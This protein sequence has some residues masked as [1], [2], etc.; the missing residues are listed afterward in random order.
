M[1][2]TEI[3]VVYIEDTPA[4]ATFLGPHGPIGRD[5]RR[6]G[7]RLADRQRI[8]AP[9]RTGRLASEIGVSRVERYRAGLE[10][11]VGANPEWFGIRGYAW[12]QSQGTHAHTIRPRN[13]RG[14]LAFRVAGKLVFT[15][16]VRHPGTRPNPYLTRW[17]TEAVL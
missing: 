1:T 10:I 8:G 4:L 6:R 3:T 12:Y 7:E 13:P 2:E 11:R 16:S 9:R 5:L 15:S 17:L 14:Y